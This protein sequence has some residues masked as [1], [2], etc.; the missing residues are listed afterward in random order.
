M[1]DINVLNM[2]KVGLLYLQTLKRMQPPS[3]PFDTPLNAT[4]QKK[5]TIK[6]TGKTENKNDE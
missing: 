6:S 2:Q 3:L 4:K 5:A 1:L